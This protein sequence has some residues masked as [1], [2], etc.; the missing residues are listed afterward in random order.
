MKMTA[1]SWVM[2]GESLNSEFVEARFEEDGELFWIGCLHC[3][4]LHLLVRTDSSL[5]T[6]AD[7]YDL[8]DPEKRKTLFIS[9]EDPTEKRDIAEIDVDGLLAMLMESNYERYEVWK[10]S[11]SE[12]LD[13]IAESDSRDAFAATYNCVMMLW[14]SHTIR[15]EFGLPE[16]V[17]GLIEFTEKLEQKG[18]SINE[19]MIRKA[20]EFYSHSPLDS[21]EVL[22][23]W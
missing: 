4:E 15:G 13:E 20:Y 23:M 10:G 1:L 7:Q 3:D 14:Y 2:P 5:L 16:S 11:G 19:Y 18:T 9:D 8:G 21:V 6:L 12:G 17:D 22:E